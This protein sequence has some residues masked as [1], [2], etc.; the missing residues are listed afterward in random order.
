M[1]T[2][3]TLLLC[4]TGSAYG[5]IF[6]ALLLQSKTTVSSPPVSL[7]VG[8]VGSKTIYTNSTSAGVSVVAPA[9]TPTYYPNNYNILG[10]Y[11]NDWGYRKRILID[12]A[13]VQANLTDFPVLINQTSDSG[14]VSH[15]QSNGNDIVF[16]SSDGV[17]KL[18]H[19]IEKYVSATGALVAWVKVP[20]ISSSA[21]TKLYMYYG[22]PTC[23]SQQDPKNVWDGYFK[24]VWH[25]N[26]D[27]SGTAPQMKDSTSN[28][29]N[30]TS[31][32]VMMTSDQVP[33]RIDGSLDFD[34]S[35]D[36]IICGNAASLQITTEITIEAWARTSSTGAT[37]G[38]VSKHNSAAPY[39]GY[40]LRK[41]S[42]D[43]YR[44]ATGNPNGAGQY[45]AS[46]S[47][48]TDS[49]WHY[50]VGV[51]RS[52]TNYLYIDGVQQTATTTYAITESGVNFVI[53]R[54]YAGYDNFWWLGDIDE[55]RVSNM[56]RSASWVATCYNNQNSP[57]TFYSVSSNEEQN[58]KVS[59]TLP[60]SLQTVDSNYF[61]V[62]SSAS[63]T[64]TTAYN[65]SGYSLLGSTALVSGNTSNLVSNN[66][67]YM[68]FRSY[69][70]TSTAKT[71]AFIAYRDSTTSLNTPKGRTWTG[72]TTSWG[73]QGE[74]P[75]SGSPVRFVRV[76]YSPNQTR[77]NEKIVVTLSDDGYLDAYVWNGT[78]WLTTNNIG[79]VGTTAN[80]YRAFDLAYE[81]TSGKAML[82]YA[83]ASTDT[84]RDLAYKTWNGTAWSTEYYIDD[85][86]QSTDIQY[87]WVGLASKP[88]G[89]SNEIALV[90]IEGSHIVAWIWN[91]SSW[92]N[93]NELTA[94]A[95]TNLMEDAAVAYEQTSGKA[96]FG[97]GVSSGNIQ[98]KIWTGTGWNN[99]ASSLNIDGATSCWITMKSDPAS[100]NIMLTSV[101]STYD[102]NTFLW[103][104]SSMTWS[105]GTGTD[106]DASVDV[107]NRR[108]AD[109]AWEPTGSK[110]LLVWG[111]TAGYITYRTF[112][113]PSTWGT[114]QNVAMG[115]IYN[116][117]HWIQLR[118]NPRSISGDVKIL[119]AVME[120]TA[121][122]IGAISWDGTNFNV[123]GTTTISAATGSTA[124]ECFE[125]EFQRFGPR[126]FASEVEFTGASNTQSWTQ[127]AWSID[128]SWTISSVTVT[129]Q[130]YNYTSGAY[131]TSGDGYNSYTSSATAGT[132][133]TKTRTTIANPNNFQNGTGYW[134]I[135]IKGVKT[136]P[137]QFDFKADWIEFKPSYYSE[138][139]ASTEFLFSSMTKNTPTQLNF[140]I[141]SEYSIASVS[142]TI[143]VW[144]YSSSAYVNSGEGYLTYTSSGVNQTKFRLIATNPQFYTS[145]GNAKIKITGVLTTTTQYQQKLNQVKLFY[146][147]SSSS[148]YNYVLKIVNQVTDAWKI[149]LT[150]YSQ[151]NIGRLN[152]C[153][154]YFRS[155]SDGTSR[156]IYIVSG[157]CLNATGPWYDLP[158]SPAERY[159][160]VA[161]QANN[162]EVSYVYVYLEI[163]V[164]NITT[165]AR[166]VI[167]FEIT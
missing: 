115:S 1:M 164:P 48:Y 40:Q 132:D 36:E 19:Q 124:Y 140:T 120:A 80:A 150:T 72:N 76:E 98:S 77:M 139:T 165:Y 111:T 52:G 43:Y 56:G 84:T 87:Y 118:R 122:D 156:Q 86:T 2:I 153:T 109:F 138:Y 110:G 127:L 18:S 130:V 21:D 63:A 69:E 121:N 143:Q 166:Y 136:T 59:G 3:I 68:Q 105:R 34:G 116:V 146:S 101:D 57:S 9:P 29:N 28:G 157:A 137:T 60:T 33:G 106:H 44:F 148:N 41:Y 6:N 13:Q 70:I 144:N 81:K 54:A 8:P 15:A 38:I 14:L 161:L 154:I 5:S 42:D 142:V 50:I 16:S 75:I 107:N 26:E 20:S 152:N 88:T 126:Q 7:Q 131:P 112:T 92:G 123:I 159:I 53:G 24:G 158:T 151:S 95:A 89:S 30:G 71:D 149:R 135:K 114:I 147:Y 32:G 51:R 47:A 117:H 73:S 58:P 37:R 155:S 104:A 100:D 96:I 78:S 93:I 162:S 31:A 125:I 91:G 108:C 45:I 94:T 49:G 82:V 85:T 39:N 65:P 17:T 66:D 128:S 79:N 12:H 102:L 35:N 113:A 129:I 22:N 55:V 46:D 4:S 167:T 74:L 119:G 64:S 163:L 99:T 27:P 25:L 145:K 160:V 83:I 103:T 67:V 141:V 97:Y 90:G 61:V 11:A 10:W 133:E 62:R 23:G 134:K